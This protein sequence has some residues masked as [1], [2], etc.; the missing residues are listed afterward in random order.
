MLVDIF[1][2]D[3]EAILKLE[4]RRIWT[5]RG[6]LGQGVGGTTTTTKAPSWGLVPRQPQN[7][8][9]DESYSKPDRVQ[10]QTRTYRVAFKQ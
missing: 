5:I 3:N 1:V 9:H 6:S 4:R 7:L 8:A 10:K 2:D